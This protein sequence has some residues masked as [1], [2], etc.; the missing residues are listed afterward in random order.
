MESRT[1]RGGAGAD[2]RR[3]QGARPHAVRDAVAHDPAG[4]PGHRSGAL[5]ARPQSQS[6]ERARQHRLDQADEV[7]RHLVGD[8]H[9][10]DDLEL[11]TEARRDDGEHASGTSTSPRRTG[12]AACW[13]RAGTPGGTATGSQNRNAFSFTQAYPDYDLAGGRRVRA[14]EGRAAHRAQRDV[15][16][17]PELRAAAGQRLRPLPVAR[18]RRHQDRLRH[19]HTSEGHSHYSQFMVHTTAR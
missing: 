17:H 7:R 4:R 14:V 6:A 10:H 19:R 12:S 1:L 18:P 8:A 15:G 11:G 9:Q 13:S 2:G 3:H 16:R 5:G